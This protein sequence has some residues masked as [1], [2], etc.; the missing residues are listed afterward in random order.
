MKQI[1]GANNRKVA[2]I[3]MVLPVDS[4]GDYAFD[5]D[6]EPV[7]GK[8]PIVLTVPRFDTM[9]RRQLKAIN[10]DL[11]ALDDKKGDDGE[12]LSPQDKSLEV[13]LTMLRPFV[14]DD[15][16]KV[17]GQ[18]KQIELDQIAT[19]WQEQSTISLG[20]LLASTNS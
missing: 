19:Y 18:L 20:E 13:V 16:L 8:Q 17:V 12:P 7:P 2:R 1:I 3:K 15:D 9:E 6:G 10:K 14:G 11:A 4:N 5:E